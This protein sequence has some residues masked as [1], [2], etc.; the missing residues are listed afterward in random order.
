MI[1]LEVGQKPKRIWYDGCLIIQL[2]QDSSG[3]Q[4][5]LSYDIN[6]C[7]EYKLLV[8]IRWKINEKDRDEIRVELSSVYNW[9]DIYDELNKQFS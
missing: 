4:K 3:V 1:G 5:L 7:I 2:D 9:L 8:G 6:P